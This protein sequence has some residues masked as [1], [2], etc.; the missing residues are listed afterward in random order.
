MKIVSYVGPQNNRIEKLMRDPKYSDCIIYNTDFKFTDINSTDQLCEYMRQQSYNAHTIYERFGITSIG[1]HNLSILVTGKE[2]DAHTIDQMPDSVFHNIIN[3]DSGTIL[4]YRYIHN[5]L[6]D[7][8]SYT[9]N[10]S[11]MLLTTQLYN[12]VNLYRHMKLFHL[13]AQNDV[14]FVVFH[15]WLDYNDV[16]IKYNN[17]RSSEYSG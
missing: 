1:G 8:N 14:S 4:E 12:Y 7:F 5:V 2:F 13:V 17:L 16:Y 10:Y 6:S 9:C 15:S 11:T 3:V